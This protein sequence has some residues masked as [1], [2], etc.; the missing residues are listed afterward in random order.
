[1]AIMTVRK[2][3]RLVATVLLS[4][5]VIAYV[6]ICAWVKL[7]EHKLV[8]ARDWPPVPIRESLGL[9]PEAVQIGNLGDV[10]LF[11]WSIRSLPEDSAANVWVLYF[12]GSGENVT[13]HQG[14]FYRLR[15]LGFNVLAPEYPGY[16]GKP[17]QPSEQAVE[18]EA[19]LA[20]DY[21]HKL[22]KVPESNIV[23]WGMSIGS[24]VAVDLAN[25]N[26]AGA[27]A[28]ITPY[29]SLVAV[30]KLRYPWIPISLLASDRFESDKKIGAVRAPVYIWHTVEDQVFPIEQAR[31][32]YELAPNPKHFEEAHG[33]HVSHHDYNF[34]VHVQQFLNASAGYQLRSP[35][36]PI[37]E[38]TAATLDSQS[39]QAALTQY[40]TLRAEH[41]NEYEFTEFDLSDLGYSELSKGNT[42]NAIAILK[43]NAEEYPKSFD[44]YDSLGEAYEKSGNTQAAIESFRHSVEIYPAA[45][46]YSR[47]KLD[48]LLAHAK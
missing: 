8:F 18:R 16:A 19:Q 31:R 44:M 17:G 6:G 40:R 26:R 46:N 5:A 14:E 48:A 12:H 22:K 33:P 39:V 34:F 7:N 47:P 36:K 2:R 37:G 9:Q 21:L 13:S 38:V 4:L 24:G 42:A 27:I 35:R 1:V 29:T 10:P 20:F 3:L 25:H 41:A 11:A 28:L 43:L 15:N 32:I 45:D 23:I 30:G